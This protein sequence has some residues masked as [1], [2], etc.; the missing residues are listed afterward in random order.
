MCDYQCTSVSFIKLSNRIE[1]IRKID[2][3]AW[4]EPNRIE[5]FSPESEC[6]TPNPNPKINQKKQNNTGMKFNRVI[7]KS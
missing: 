4:I 3:S 1:S 2:S 5:L 6:S 7:S